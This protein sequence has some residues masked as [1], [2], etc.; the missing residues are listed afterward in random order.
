MNLITRNTHFPIGIH[1]FDDHHRYLIALLSTVHDD[2]IQQK[3][4][5]E[6]VKVFAGLTA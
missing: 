4:D 5:L 1:E 3:A 2:F 6:L